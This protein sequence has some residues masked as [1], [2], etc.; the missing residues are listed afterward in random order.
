MAAGQ[1][2]GYQV[3]AGDR[4]KVLE[5]MTSLPLGL[6]G[7]GAGAESSERPFSSALHP[8]GMT[9]C[10]DPQASHTSLLP[11]KHLATSAFGLS[12]G[13]GLVDGT[14]QL[15]TFHFYP[16]TSTMETGH[17]ECPS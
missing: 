8:L 16:V 9:D 3:P 4:M 7:P 5:I 2:A 10:T 6:I 1:E 11:A 15:V 12:I 14:W 17:S 13:K